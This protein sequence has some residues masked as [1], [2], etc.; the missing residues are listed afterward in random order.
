MTLPYKLGAKPSRHD[1][2]DRDFASLVTLERAR[3]AAAID[4]KFYTM[5]GPDFRINQEAEGTC[6]GHA[7]T[8][9]LLAG[10]SEHDTF[11][12]FQTEALA[13]EFARRLYF[14]A[15]GDATYQ[16]GAYPRDA[17]DALVRQGRI[18]SYWKVMQVDDITTC[19]LTYGPVTIAI[20]WYWS[21]FY[22][23]GRLSRDYGN[24]WIKVNLDSEHI[25]YHCI[26][27]TG[28]DLNPDDG[29]PPYVRVQ[30][31]WGDSW[32]QNGT[33]RL[34]IE[35]LRLLNIWDNWTFAEKTF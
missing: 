22:N 32:M 10:P 31:S 2:R 8:N 6:V 15:T 18:D 28:V 11:P 9:V 34:T 21:M 26:A 5:V 14:D 27:L 33:A 23:N 12:D 3:A 19:L 7:F 1:P 13:H 30:N 20:P 35:S 25:G 16:L 4:R 24:K 17:C 29:A